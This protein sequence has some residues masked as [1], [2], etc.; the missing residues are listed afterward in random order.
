MIHKGM[1]GDIKWLRVRARECCLL[2]AQ[3]SHPAYLNRQ[4]QFISRRSRE[5]GCEQRPNR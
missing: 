3:A 2:P 4:A 1:Q 5:Y